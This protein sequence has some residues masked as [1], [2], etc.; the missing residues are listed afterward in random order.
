[1]TVLVCGGRAYD[2]ALEVTSTLNA[3]FIAKPWQ[4]VVVGSLRGADKLVAEWARERG[5]KCTVV[6]ANWARYGRAA[7]PI[8]NGH[9]LRDYKPDMVVAFPGGTGTASMVSLARA[10]GVPVH[11]VAG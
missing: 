1:M 10:E 9:M 3:L 6:G 5:I 8:R 2:N 7:G 11:V 4:H